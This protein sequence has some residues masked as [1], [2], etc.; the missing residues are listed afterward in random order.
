MAF[1]GDNDVV[2]SVLYDVSGSHLAVTGSQVVLT[3][4]PMLI[5]AGLTGSV[6]RPIRLDINGSQFVTGS[7]TIATPSGSYGGKVEGLYP[8]GGSDDA[9]PIMIAGSDGAAVRSFLVDPL[10]RLITAPAGSSSAVTSSLET[11]YVATA[12]RTRVPVRATTY[13][14]QSTNTQRSIVS[15]NAADSAAG[16]GARTVTLTWLDQNFNGPYSETITLNGT[17]PVNT[18]ATNICYIQEMRV[19]TA[20]SGGQNAGVISLKAATSGGGTTIASIATGDNRIFYAMH[21]VPDGKITYITGI[22]VSHDG[23]VVGSGGVFT[24]LA[25]NLSI[26]NSVETQISD[27]IRQYG[28]SSNTFRS[29]GT[30]IKVT[31]PARIQVYVTPESSSALVYRAALDLYDQ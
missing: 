24:I 11:G 31:G 10:G 18:V 8:D 23:T 29:W 20:G 30:A 19:A 3:S 25:K 9:N 13:T 27:F 28:Q 16:T 1:S 6:V 5:V 4:Q 7:M 22:S 12:A 2:D 15:A 26:P 14:E 17:T 21:Y